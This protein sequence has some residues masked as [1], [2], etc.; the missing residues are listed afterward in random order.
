MSIPLERLG[1]SNAIN[2]AH[3]ARSMMLP[4]LQTLFRAFPV[5]VTPDAFRVGIVDENVLDKPTYGSR[6]KSIHHLTQLY[7]LDPD[8]ALFRVLWELG[9]M[10]PEAVPQLCLV[11]AYARDPQLRFSFGYVQT[12]RPGEAHHRSAMEQHLEA[13]FPGRFSAA[14]KKSMAQNVSTSWTVAGHLAGR[15]NKTRRLP[16]PRPASAAYAMFV[17]YLSGLRGERLL[18]SPYAALVSSSRSQLQ[19]S[20]ALA[21]ARGLLRF[22]HAAG[23]FEFDFSSLLTPIEQ[24]L[25]NESD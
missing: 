13:G 2:G 24:A 6:L 7:G 12:L 14:M 23:V 5:K 16:E 18:E 9:H 4:E 25:V 21:S 8:K 19:A 20:L 1:F 3:S 11:C 10:D 17:G 15:V 22:K